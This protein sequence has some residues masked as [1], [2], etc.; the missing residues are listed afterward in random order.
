MLL[1]GFGLLAAWPWVLGQRPEKGAPRAE[2]VRY[3]Q[4]L[5][6]YVG[7][8]TVCLISTGIGAALI[9]RQTRKAFAEEAEANM[10]LLIEGTLNA[11]R[12][13]SEKTDHD[14]R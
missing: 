13:K 2:L 14:G 7:G 4:N 9:V 11:H 8:M 6:W 3:S 5:G 12:Q 10:R 1:I